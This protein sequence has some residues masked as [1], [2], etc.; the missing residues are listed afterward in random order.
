MVVKIEDVD[1][2]FPYGL[3]L[4]RLLDGDLRASYA[5]G[6]ASAYCW[7]GDAADGAGLARLKMWTTPSTVWLVFQ[8]VIYQM[9][10][11]ASDSGIA[12][13]K[14]FQTG[15]LPATMALATPL[16]G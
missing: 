10:Q 2:P 8:L 6:T 9:F 14:E 3:A 15:N 11:L 16:E 1:N 7:M 13:T 4:I 5:T 12:L